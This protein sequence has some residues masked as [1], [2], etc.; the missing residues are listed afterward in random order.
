MTTTK[1]FQTTIPNGFGHDLD[2]ILCSMKLKHKSNMVLSMP[3]GGQH[4]YKKN[5]FQH[6]R[7]E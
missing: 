4:I 5:T 3:Q 7:G 1:I 6:L 2:P